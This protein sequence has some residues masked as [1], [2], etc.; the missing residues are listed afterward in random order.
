M[1]LKY[2]SDSDI[3]ESLESIY[4]QLNTPLKE[5][6]IQS[7]ERC[8]D[9]Y[10][11]NGKDVDRIEDISTVFDEVSDSIRARTGIQFN[12]HVASLPIA[13]MRY[14]V[15]VSIPKTA[16]ASA[17]STKLNDRTLGQ[18]IS[19]K[20]EHLEVVKGSMDLKA[21]KVTGFY[22]D[23]KFDLNMDIDFFRPKFLNNEEL[24]AVVFHELGHAWDYMFNLGE[25][26]RTGA[27]TGATFEVLRGRSSIEKKLSLV[28]VLSPVLGQDIEDPGDLDDEEIVALVQANSFTRRATVSD[29]KE[30]NAHMIEFMADQFAARHGL[31]HAIA[32]AQRKLAN[33]QFMLFRNH[34]FQPY[35]FGGAFLAMDIF[36]IAMVPY[37]LYV[38]GRIVLGTVASKFAK[39]FLFS[40]LVISVMDMVGGVVK[41][42]KVRLD[43]I[44]TDLVSLLKDPHLSD[45]TKKAILKDIDGLDTE[46][47]DI[48]VDLTSPF[49]VVSSFINNMGRMDLRA[50]N[51]SLN[52]NQLTNNRLY[53]L[54]ERIRLGTIN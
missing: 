54:A 19:G 30:Y 31:A 23:I 33:E 10:A 5:Y 3:A 32:T 17:V 46:I 6:L 48:S 42:P 15:N 35:W 28:K 25:A 9:A 8:K 16:V 27:I 26:A 40:W 37:S 52:I 44:R 49:S 2:K 1:A 43:L 21:L 11:S 39:T 13:G 7:M 12:M 45:D 34:R 14:N 51:T 18:L 22:T 36:S 4:Y 47:D 50:F 53:E 38:G 29:S 41:D 24:T 20:Y